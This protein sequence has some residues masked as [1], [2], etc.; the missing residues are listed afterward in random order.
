MSAADY[1]LL[2]GACAVVVLAVLGV[3]VY[4]IRSDYQLTGSFRVSKRNPPQ[5]RKDKAAEATV[6]DIARGAA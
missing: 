2:I 1:A 5:P 3:T 4:L 6:T